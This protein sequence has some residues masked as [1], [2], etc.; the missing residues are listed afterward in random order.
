MII[1]FSP[2][3]ILTESITCVINCCEIGNCFCQ[4]VLLQN[5][6]GA[7]EQRFNVHY[8]SKGDGILRE[9]R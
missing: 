4:E 7:K 8:S 1:F 2:H 9:K 3:I 6:A 5:Y